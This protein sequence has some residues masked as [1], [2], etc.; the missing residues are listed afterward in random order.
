MLNIYKFQTV[1]SVLWKCA[2]GYIE[3]DLFV[4]SLLSDI[5]SSSLTQA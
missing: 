5:H 3:R 4:S 2:V 1:I